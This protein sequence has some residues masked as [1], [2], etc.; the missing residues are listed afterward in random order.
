MS[1]SARATDCQHR[2]TLASWGG[3]IQGQQQAGCT[4]VAGIDPINKA[5]VYPIHEE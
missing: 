1:A 3:S 4:C 5:G 2:A